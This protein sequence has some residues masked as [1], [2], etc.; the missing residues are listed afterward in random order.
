MG[1]KRGALIGAGM[2]LIA[3][4]LAHLVIWY[5][6]SRADVPF[7]ANVPFGLSIVLPFAALGAVVGG[8]GG[9]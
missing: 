3:A 4:C 7:A 2:G 8:Q 1:W 6:A 9:R 5:G